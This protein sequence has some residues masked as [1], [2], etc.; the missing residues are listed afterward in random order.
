M[1]QPQNI[2][3]IDDNEDF[4][5]ALGARLAAEGFEVREAS[6]GRAGLEAAAQQPYDLILL[7]MLMPEK[8]GVTTYQELRA[9]PATRRIPI[10]LLT[11]AAVE[12]H[13]EPMPYE[14]DGLAFIMGKPYDVKILLA[15]IRQVL[16]QVQGGS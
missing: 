13:W 1:A 2:L 12:G 8:D 6:S 5:K 15:R 4:R 14:T 9:E 3:L 11:G 10:I 7:D 16:T